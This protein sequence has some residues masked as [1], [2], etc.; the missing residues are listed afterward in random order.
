ML[1]GI[2][3]IANS[4][5]PL[6]YIV[7]L[8]LLDQFNLFIAEPFK[9]GRNL[10]RE[11]LGAVAY[12][13]LQVVIDQPSTR[14]NQ[15]YVQIVER[16]TQM[17]RALTYDNREVIER[18]GQWITKQMRLGPLKLNRDGACLSLPEDFYLLFEVRQPFI[19]LAD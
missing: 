4:T 6:V 7:G 14:F 2:R 16:S 3:Q 10:T 11:I 13:K 1:V 17:L 19:A 15:C 9:H 12:W 5:K 8:Q 18:F